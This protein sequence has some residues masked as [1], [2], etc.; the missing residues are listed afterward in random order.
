MEST[1]RSIDNTEW[2]PVNKESSE[3]SLQI[4]ERKSVDAIDAYGSKLLPLRVDLP[5]SLI[6]IHSSIFQS[7]PSCDWG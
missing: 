4:S 1:V 3:T 6:P 2:I 5:P 7:T